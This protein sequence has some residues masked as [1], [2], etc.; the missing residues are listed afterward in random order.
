M[1]IKNPGFT[2]INIVKFPKISMLFAIIISIIGSIF[3]LVVPLF[4]R[5]L[6]DNFTLFTEHKQYLLF[7]VLI[8]LLSSIFNGISIFLL[9]KIGESIIYSLIQKVW[10]H[11]LKL[12]PSF[13]NK[14][15]NG[16]LLSRI[17]DDTT[18]INNF[19]TQVIPTFFPTMITL[20]GSIVLLFIL[21]WQTALI[22]LS[23]IPLYLFLII[24]LSKVMQ[25][26]AYDTQLE[27]A[28]LSGTISNVLSEINLVKT[29]NTE[30]KEFNNTKSKLKRLYNL[31]IK[32]GTINAIV[33]PITTVLMLISMGSVLA[34]GGF[35]VSNGAI[36]AGT[37]I[38]II[39][40]LIQL[41][42][43]IEHMANLFTGYKK[44][45]GS[46]LR[47]IEIMKE[48][49]E[50]LDYTH[51]YN[52]INSSSITFEN[53]NFSYVKDIQVLKDCSFIIPEKKLTALVGPSGS[54]KTTIFNIIS[55]LY[56]IN[57]GKVLYGEKS[58]YD[59]PLNDWRNNVGYVMQDN[60][61][62]SG[63]IKKNICYPLKRKPKEAEISYY[64]DLANINSFITKLKNGYSTITGETGIQ[65]SGG[66]KQR[67]DIARNF[68]KNPT[69][70]LLD[71]ATSNLDSE[72]EM[73][74]Q[75]ALSNI[76]QNRTTVVIAHRLSTILKADKIIFV[77]EGRI[78]GMGTHD[79]LINN[80]EKYSAMVNLQN[81]NT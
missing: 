4:T 54:G 57:S 12:K 44:M 15:E 14:N 45:Q 67:I 38:A 68:I 18:V 73:S 40:Y 7:F 69:L 39:F 63:T 26:I 11:I 46:S 29:S 53:V 52:S 8:F 9:T 27:T 31:G 75:K 17:I 50:N 28:N 24:P 30:Y 1:N 43:P 62:I 6:V 21:D 64:S 2:L 77:D 47:L 19:I 13:F 22:A 81:L 33:S 37:L 61:M 71:E 60:G 80:H 72:S 78:T 42:E 23:S 48:P 25:N 41:T 55:R 36:S 10:L 56:E 76:S 66:E 59:Y 32:E 5:K 58:I 16:A 79:Y 49:E 51:S 3:Q 70:L 35:R 74:I 20:F 65:L 34:F